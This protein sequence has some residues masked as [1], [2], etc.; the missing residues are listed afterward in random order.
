MQLYNPLTIVPSSGPLSLWPSHSF[1]DPNLIK[2]C[3]PVPT[4]I[5]WIPSRA[6]RAF[7]AN[8]MT[9]LVVLHLVGSVALFAWGTVGSSLAVLAGAA[10]QVLDATADAAPLEALCRSLWRPSDELSFGTVRLSTLVRFGTA[11]C[12]MAACLLLTIEIVHRSLHLEAPAPH[13]LHVA[14]AGTAP[15]LLCRCATGA[16]SQNGPPVWEVVLRIGAM[17]AC[18]QALRNTAQLPE[19]PLLPHADGI[20]AAILAA[21]AV[22]RS[23]LQ[24][25]RTGRVLL[26]GAP[27]ELLPALDQRL[28]QAR[29][30]PGIEDTRLESFWLLDE[31]RTVGSLRLV[32]RA[33]A[34]AERAVAEV[35]ALFADVL[36]HLALQVEEGAHGSGGAQDSLAPPP[37]SEGPPL[38][39]RQRRVALDM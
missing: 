3:P 6:N 35:R 23:Y 36:H 21:V 39:A 4:I 38:Q 9:W 15:V 7:L 29:S 1:W 30:L 13:I 10:H 32:L 18:G 16:S 24:A 34:D 8:A 19:V 17:L 31:E 27:V 2:K 37:P 14:A 25:R 22:W 12:T 28:L 11:T 26:Q 20:S 33:G 5:A